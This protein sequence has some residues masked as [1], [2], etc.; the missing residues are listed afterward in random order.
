MRL[1]QISIDRVRGV[2]NCL[3]IAYICQQEQDSSTL[4]DMGAGELE[5][6]GSRHL[7]AGV[8]FACD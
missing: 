6:G 1:E 2:E 3:R 7:P 5:I 8:G 4:K